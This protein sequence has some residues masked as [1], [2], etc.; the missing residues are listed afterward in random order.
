[1]AEA[2]DLLLG[3]QVAQAGIGMGNAFAQ[4]G[5]IRSQGRFEAARDT[6]NAQNADLQAQGALYRGEKEA[7][8]KAYQ[9]RKLIGAQRAAAAANGIAADTGSPLGAQVKAA[10]IGGLDENTIRTGAYL[11]SLGYKMSSAD[12]RTQATLAKLSAGNASRATL[13]SGGLGA[14][15][16]IESGLYYRDKYSTP[17]SDPWADPSRMLG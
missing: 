11:N 16:D 14:A 10:E 9:T 15:R 17:Q 5:A 7:Q 2:S 6:L 13:L 8:A 4:S 1:M 12:L 3:T